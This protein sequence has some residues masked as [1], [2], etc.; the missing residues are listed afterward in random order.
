M[1]SVVTRL[2]MSKM[3]DIP[4][5]TKKVAVKAAKKDQPQLATRST[6]VEGCL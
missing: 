1:S 6:V 2:V 4:L 5:P 3:M